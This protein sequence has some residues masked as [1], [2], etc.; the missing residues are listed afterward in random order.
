MMF[1]LLDP[2]VWLLALALAGVSGGFGY[3]KGRIDGHKLGSAAVQARWDSAEAQ[4]REAAEKAEKK[5]RARERAMQEKANAAIA[6]SNQRAVRARADADAA[7]GSE[8]LLRDELDAF[9]A[10]SS[11]S[12]ENSCAAADAR[13]SAVGEL[14]AA[15]TEEYRGLATKAQGH[16]GDALS[17]REAWPTGEAK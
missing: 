9:R 6:Q 1:T 4:R 7:R 17:A 14:L 8:R 12:P 16:L 5:S 15:C 10:R 3:F 2:R 13:T 11:R